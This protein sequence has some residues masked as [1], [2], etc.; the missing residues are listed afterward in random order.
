MDRQR[1]QVPA[2]QVRPA[3]EI[4]QYFDPTSRCRMVIAKP[5]EHPRLWGDYLTGARASYRRHGVENVLDYER[6]VDGESTALFFAA[7]DRHGRVVGGMRAQGPYVVSGQAHAL[8]E[9]AGR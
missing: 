6:V 9:W 3:A 4:G 7:V 8:E 1:L 2:P 5:S